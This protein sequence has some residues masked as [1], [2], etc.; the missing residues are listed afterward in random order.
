MTKQAPAKRAGKPSTAGIKALIATASLGA[1]FGGWVL[2]STHDNTATQLAQQVATSSDP[3]QTLALDLSALSAQP[4]IQPLPTLIPPGLLQGAF[5]PQAQPFTTV[6]T[7]VHEAIPQPTRQPLRLVKPPAAIKPK[8]A[9]ITTTR[10][11]R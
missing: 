6:P 7:P 4:D 11:S 5:S 2:F 10:S 1:T 8:P 3:P 9:P